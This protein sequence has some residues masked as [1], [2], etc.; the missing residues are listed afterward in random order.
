[1][2]LLMLTKYPVIIRKDGI[3]NAEMAIFALGYISPKFTICTSITRHIKTAR[4]KLM[5]LL[6]FILFCLEFNVVCKVSL[7]FKIHCWY[8]KKTLP[9]ELA[10]F[11]LSFN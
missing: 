2:D 4:K 1:M 5:S 7:F 11:L 6:Y 3:I 8:H 10:C 9:K